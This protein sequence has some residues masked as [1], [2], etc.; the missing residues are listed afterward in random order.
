MKEE[1]VLE[2]KKERPT[3]KR[4]AN[5]FTVMSPFRSLKCHQISFS[6]FLFAK[7]E[8]TKQKTPENE[9]TPFNLWLKYQFMNVVAFSPPLS[10][11]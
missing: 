2:A 9:K 11:S 8:T 1:N 10:V 3:K 5:R 7:K 6:V 4:G